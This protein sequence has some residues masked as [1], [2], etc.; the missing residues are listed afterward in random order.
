MSALIFFVIVLM[1]AVLA[2]WIVRTTYTSTSWSVRVDAAVTLDGTEIKG[3]PITLDLRGR[4]PTKM[5]LSDS[6]TIRLEGDATT[7]GN[8]IVSV[9]RNVD[10]QIELL[11]AN[12]DVDGDRRQQKHIPECGGNIS[13]NWSVAPKRSGFQEIALSASWLDEGG[14]AYE[15]ATKLYRIKIVQFLGL[16]APQIKFFS[17]LL[18]AVAMLTGIATALKELGLLNW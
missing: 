5:Y 12:F 1:V 15:I 16:T 9:P 10:V 8:S 6:S 14:K 3:P 2:W 7:E 17:G 4:L 11:A 18:A 13:F